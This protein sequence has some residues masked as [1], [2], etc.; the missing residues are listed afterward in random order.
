[1]NLTDYLRHPRNK[2]ERRVANRAKKRERE[3]I[4]ALV[5]KIHRNGCTVKL[6]KDSYCDDCRC[7]HNRFDKGSTGYCFECD[8]EYPCRT[9]AL[10]KGEKSDD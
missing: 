3:R 6:D 9:I 1:M 5:G 7:F 8:A 4:I 10:V 2:R